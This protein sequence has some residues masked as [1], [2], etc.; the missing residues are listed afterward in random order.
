MGRINVLDKHM[1]EL[2]AA[3]EVVERPAS[4]IKEMV[5][6]SID[7][8]S[9]VITVEIKNGG[10]SFMRVADNGCGIMRDDVRKAFLRHATSKIKDQ[11]DLDKIGT[12]GFRGEALASISAV[13]DL[14]LITRCPEDFMG[15]SYRIKG[16]EELQLEDVGCPAGTTF[17]VRELFYNIPARMKF[18]KKDVSEGNAV[19]AIMDRLALAHP[20]IAFTYIKDGKTA[21][22]TTGD[23]KLR[24][25]IYSVF[26]R[27]F[28]NTLMPVDYT[29]EGVH[30]YGFISMPVHSRPNRNMQ[31]FFINGRYVKTK[32]GTV[33]LEEACK[34]S[35]MVGKFPACVL[36]IDLDFSMVDVNVHPAKTEVRFVNEKPVFEA[37]YHG[38]KSA[39]LKE[40]RG[41][42]AEINGGKGAAPSSFDGG[43]KVN[44]FEM[45]QMLFRKR[46]SEKEPSAF[47]T[48]YTQSD[49][50]EKGGVSKSQSPFDDRNARPAQ[51]ST[52]ENIGAAG[53]GKKPEKDERDGFQQ[54]KPGLEE[55]IWAAL[56][57][58]EPAQSDKADNKTKKAGEKAAETEGKERRDRAQEAQADKTAVN[59]DGDINVFYEAPEVSEPPQDRNAVAGRMKKVTPSDEYLKALKER[60]INNMKTQGSFSA[61]E[62]EQDFNDVEKPISEERGALKAFAAGEAEGKRPLEEENPPET[63]SLEDKMGGS[64]PRFVGEIF[65][66]YII[67][68]TD[69]GEMLLVDKHAAHERILYEKL[70]REKGQGFSQFLLEPVRVLLDKTDY[71]SCI[72][73]LDMLKNAG[74]EAED[75][76][77][78]TL[79]IRSAPQYLDEKDIHDSIVEMAG[80][81]SKNKKDIS[82]ERMDFIYHNIACRAAVKGGNINSEAELMEIVKILHE[83]PQLK[84]CP[85][86]RPIV[87]SISKREIEKQFG[88]V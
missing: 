53:A 6:N 20:E 59:R 84:Y 39:L 71:D 27:E 73:N 13:S 57:A 5:E 3:G 37:V 2:I 52:Y 86:G 60:L 43:R 38:V 61:A 22:K 28:V 74:F 68:E 63:V 67:L 51:R 50:R 76:G 31:N 19:S 30:V 33:A 83:N 40:D 54:G 78:G 18:L 45:A 64:L 49:R 44:P 48:S 8:G 56:D 69:K 41:K 34:G 55:D 77:Y 87:V 14:T 25:A 79:I 24:S 46:D 29:L 10:V 12:L 66:T 65:N 82:T 58:A 4:V 21:L 1:A 32:T 72:E 17:I 62:D 36:N 11:K 9:S 81:I 85:H 70:K 26:G 23:G 15:T 88:R 16:G 7:A 35:V 75:F 42:Q 80:Y 47:N